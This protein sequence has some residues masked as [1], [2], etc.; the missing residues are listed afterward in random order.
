MNRAVFF[1]ALRRRGSG[2]FGTSLTQQQVEGLTVKLDVWAKWYAD[3]YPVTFLAAALGQ[4]YRET[5][6]KMVPVLEAYASSRA[7]AA[8]ALE[9]AFRAGKLTWVKTRYWLPDASG[10]IGV[11]GGDIQLTHR[12]NYVKANEKIKARFGADIGL[13]KDY[14]KIL[15]PVVSA[16]VMFQGMVDGWFTGKK[17]SDYADMKTGA[18]NYL[19]ARDIVNGDKKHVGAEIVRN[20]NAFETALRE[21]GAWAHFGPPEHDVNLKVAA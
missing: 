8:A 6:G 13:D 17:L 4:G 15:D 9:R 2:V 16:I 5:G 18:V 21:A 7:G 19:D 14:D 1:T 12:A 10:Q 3:K 11:G 20:C